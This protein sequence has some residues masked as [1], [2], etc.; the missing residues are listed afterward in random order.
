MWIKGEQRFSNLVAD[1]HIWVLTLDIAPFECVDPVRKGLFL[2]DGKV[3]LANGSSIPLNARP[4]ETQNIRAG[5]KSVCIDGIHYESALCLTPETYDD[6]AVLKLSLPQDAQ[7]IEGVIG[8]DYPPE[9]N[10]APRQLLAARIVGEEACFVSV[11]EVHEGE[12]QVVDVVVK[13]NTVRIC[14]PAGKEQTVEFK[15]D[16]SV[17]FAEEGNRE[18]SM[19]AVRDE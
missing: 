13:E 8:V 4:F 14:L 11:Y 2:A 9:L 7:R 10:A 19:P 16:G 1:M 12:K 3:F 6:K 5:Q 17:C 15:E 18:W